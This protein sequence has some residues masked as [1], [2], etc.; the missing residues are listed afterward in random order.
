[1]ES[2]GVERESGEVE[3]AE[4]IVASVQFSGE[5]VHHCLTNRS[6]P[7]QCH[8]TPL[9][10]LPCHATTHHFYRSV[11]TSALLAGVKGMMVI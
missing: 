9:H 3:R 8:L 11:S 6:V 7:S 4:A 10:T 2:S 1:M 5:V